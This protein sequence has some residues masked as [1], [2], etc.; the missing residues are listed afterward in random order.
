MFYIVFVIKETI[1]LRKMILIRLEQKNKREK[2]KVCNFLIN[3]AIIKKDIL[4]MNPPPHHQKNR[5]A[6]ETNCNSEI[7]VKNRTP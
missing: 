1:T 5:I 4:I 7:I 2:N 3:S 6:I